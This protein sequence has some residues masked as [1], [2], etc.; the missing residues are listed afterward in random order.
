[1]VPYNDW[2]VTFESLLSDLVIHWDGALLLN[3]DLNVNLQRPDIPTTKKYS[4]ILKTMSLQ[5]V[6]SKPTRNT[7]HSSTLI[8]H[9]ITN[10]PNQVTHT[11]VISSLMIMTHLT[12]VLTFASLD[13][14]QGINISGTK[15]TLMLMLSL[16]T[17]NS[18]P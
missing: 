5:Q 12:Y 2:I 11:D 14:S 15:R 8:D 13:L 10:I 17:L 1:M 4:D 16:R 9:M 6:V 7:Q 3:G 18:C